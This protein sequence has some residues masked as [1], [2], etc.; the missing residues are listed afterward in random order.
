MIN[1]TKDGTIYTLGGP[2][3]A[4]VLVLIHG[5]GLNHHSWDLHVP[6]LSSHYRVLTYDLSGHGESA[7]PNGKPSLTIF[8][9]QLYL[10]LG[11]LEIEHCAVAGFSLGGMINRRFV[12]DNPGIVT[13]LGI[14]NS[15]HERGAEDQKLVED[16]AVQT[17]VNGLAAM[18]DSTIERWFTPAFRIQ[19][20]DVIY[21]VSKW[22]LAND[23]ALFAQTR[24][25]LAHGVKELIRP[26]PPIK[27]P[28]LI[29]TCENDKGSSP[30]M[31]RA[32]AAEIQ[33]A[34]IMVVPQLQHMGI[35]ERP[36]LF[37]GPLLQFLGDVL[38][39]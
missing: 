9:E 34:R 24:S 36:S 22:V 5:L 27:V 2:A 39:K 35:L 3:R 19:R 26:I 15:P 14:F 6:A 18:L 32:I 20:P 17:G 31:S 23:P 30:A 8:S 33:G 28:A 16:R 11:A 29:M 13:A 21:Q 38:I 25:V 12:M 7:P 1:R 37:T 10:L 4:P